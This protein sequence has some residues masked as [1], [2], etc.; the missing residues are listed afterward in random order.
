[1]QLQEDHKDKM[2]ILV[3]KDICLRLKAKA[4]NI[5]AED[6][7]TGK[8]KDVQTLHQGQILMNDVDERLIDTLYK[9]GFGDKTLLKLDR[10]SA[11]QYFILKNKGKS[12][13][14]RYDKQE[15]VLERVQDVEAFGIKALNAEQNFALHA[16]LDPEI[17]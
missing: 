15:D 9:S 17:K 8:V 13:L 14:A 5:F 12:V 10:V 3:S 6:Y 1:I 4:L 16:L 2:V 11:N 7:E